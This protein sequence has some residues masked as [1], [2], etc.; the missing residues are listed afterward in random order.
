[1]DIHEWVIV[2][3]FLKVGSVKNLE[4]IVVLKESISTLT[5]YSPFWERFVKTIF[6]SLAK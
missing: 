3:G 5:I 2:H 4:S 6:V 1:M